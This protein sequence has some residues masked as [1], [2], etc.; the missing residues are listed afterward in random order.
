MRKLL[1]MLVAVAILGACASAPGPK[2]EDVEETEAVTLTSI[3]G[4]E[5]EEQAMVLVAA[6]PAGAMPAGLQILVLSVDGT[7]AVLFYSAE[8]TLPGRRREDRNYVIYGQ[9]AA[10]DLASCASQIASG[11]RLLKD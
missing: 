2:P 9:C 4:P 10:S 8:L 11:A 7:S 5:I 3:F 1:L 6:E